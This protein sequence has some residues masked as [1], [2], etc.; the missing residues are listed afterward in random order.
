MPGTRL[1]AEEK[2]HILLLK[3]EGMSQTKIAAEIKRDRGAIDAYCASVA[4]THLEAQAILAAG[5][6]GVAR[7]YVGHAKKDGHHAAEY[8]DRKKILPKIRDAAPTGMRLQVLIG[9]AVSG[10]GNLVPTQA[11][12]V[13]IQAEQKALE[14]ETDDS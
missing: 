4:P 9:G 12:M 6:A 8:L 11:T 14:G 1:S 13:A 2:E 7:A 10:P 5:S 3:A